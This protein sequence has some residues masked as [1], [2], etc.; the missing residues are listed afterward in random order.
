MWG[1]RS[2]NPQ[3]KRLKQ[4]AFDKKPRNKKGKN[5]KANMFYT[6]HKNFQESQ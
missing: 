4:L 3:P 2:V 5:Q 6:G 1:R